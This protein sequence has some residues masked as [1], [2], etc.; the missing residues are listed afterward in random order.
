MYS[1]TKSVDRRHKQLFYKI[2]LAYSFKSLS[3]T[4]PR[5]IIALSCHLLRSLSHGTMRK[6]HCE[7]N[8]VEL[9]WAELSWGGHGRLLVID[10][11]RGCFVTCRTSD[12]WTHVTH[13][14]DTDTDWVYRQ[15]WRLLREL[16]LAGTGAKAVLTELLLLL[17]LLPLPTCHCRYRFEGEYNWTAA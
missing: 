17:L 1:N 7:P 9:S 10:M 13:D 5:I 3:V 4:Y 15:H 8:R 6:L 16:Q 11:R 14:M 12:E 2:T